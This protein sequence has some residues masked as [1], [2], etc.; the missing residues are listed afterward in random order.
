M[1]PSMHPHPRVVRSR[2]LLGIAIAAVPLML[3][4]GYTIAELLAGR[5]TGFGQLVPFTPLALLLLLVPW[6]PSLVGAAIA[7]CAVVVAGLVFFLGVGPL[8]LRLLTVALFVLPAFVGGDVLVTA[9][10]PLGR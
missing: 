1:L 4:A 5:P 2:E 8:E 3:L 10:R 7:L 9:E 6:R